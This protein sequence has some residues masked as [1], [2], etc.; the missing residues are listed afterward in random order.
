MIAQN[1]RTP[2]S[3]LNVMNLCCPTLYVLTAAVTGERQSFKKKK[4]KM[5]ALH[6]PGEISREKDVWTVL[7]GV[8]V[9]TVPFL[10]RERGTLRAALVG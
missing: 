5:T 8:R 2:L 1:C 9:G 3:A 10:Q 7:P 4:L 6:K